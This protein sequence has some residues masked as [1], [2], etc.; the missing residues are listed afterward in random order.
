MSDSFVTPCT[1]AHQAPLSMEFPWQEH[2]SGVP[3]PSPGDLP[4]PGIEPKSLASLA[5]A[6]SLYQLCHRGTVMSSV[7]YDSFT[8]SF[9]VIIPFY[10][11]LLYY[12]QLLESFK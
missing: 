12:L 10:F 9:G 3:F 8:S 7:N 5:L 1:V 6:G 4:N 2:W 11:F